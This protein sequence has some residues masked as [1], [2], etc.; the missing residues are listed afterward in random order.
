MF[1]RAPVTGD[2][3]QAPGG[4]QADD[5]GGHQRS[6]GKSK[7][8]DHATDLDAQRRGQCFG[9][10]RNGID[11][12][13]R[14]RAVEQGT[15][16]DQDRSHDQLRHQRSHRGVPACHAQLPRTQSLIHHRRLLVEDHPRHDHGAYVRGRQIAVMRV[17]E[18]DRR[19]LPEHLVQIRRCLERNGD[20]HQLE[21]AKSNGHP[22]HHPVG[23]AANHEDDA[24][25]GGGDQRAY[26]QRKELGDASDAT[27]LREQR[28]HAGDRK[29]ADGEP[30]PACTKA[31]ADQLA[32]PFLG[33][34][35]E[36]HGE[37]L[38]HVE[39]RHQ[40]DLQR[41]QSIAP[42]CAALRGGDDAASVG[43]GEHDHQARAEDGEQ[44]RTNRQ[45]GDATGH[46]GFQPRLR[47]G[48]IGSVQALNAQAAMD[49]KYRQRRQADDPV[50]QAQ[51]VARCI[52]D[53]VI[54]QIATEDEQPGDDQQRNPAG[55][56][57]AAR[58]HRGDVGSG[59]PAEQPDHRECSCTVNRKPG[60]LRGAGLWTKRPTVLQE[61]MGDE[62]SGS[63]EPQGKA[64]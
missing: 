11:R 35:S 22:L 41:Q 45:I 14:A 33:H 12:L 57:A 24:D 15:G 36:A 63:A 10:L 1:Q 55:L 21:E 3:A 42:G 29:G 4:G 27:Q 39:N 64:R 7:R 40:Q 49:E 32:M 17:G 6:A 34:Q 46:G 48:C 52:A 9:D 2:F 28:A 51:Q 13:R 23:A 5:D 61:V 54:Q 19:H 50:Q 59:D 60:R 8:E 53:H 31:L 18:R 56:A 62:P 37:L 30:G 26:R 20:K 43:V 44:A 38:H 16:G 25:H 58:P 47:Q